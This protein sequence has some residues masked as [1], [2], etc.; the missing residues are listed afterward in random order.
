MLLD[1]IRIVLSYCEAN[2]IPDEYKD[3]LYELNTT[4]K[5]FD[6]S[7][8]KKCKIFNLEIKYNIALVYFYK[9]DMLEFMDRFNK[10]LITNYGI[11]TIE[12]DECCGNLIMN[13]DNIDGCIFLYNGYNMWSSHILSKLNNIKK[14]SCTKLTVHNIKDVYTSSTGICDDIDNINIYLKTDKNEIYNEIWKYFIEKSLNMNDL[15]I[16]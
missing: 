3:K 2:D 7:C 11:I 6:L 12:L 16:Y 5:K 8:Y 10:K 1:I 14:L 15:I 13:L 9:Y 4:N